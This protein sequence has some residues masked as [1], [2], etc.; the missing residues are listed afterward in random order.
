[1]AS[2]TDDDD[3][4]EDNKVETFE[5]KWGIL[6]KGSKGTYFKSGPLVAWKDYKALQD[7]VKRLEQ[8]LEECEMEHLVRSE[9]M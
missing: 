8:E 6:C 4:D 9:F 1:M 2:N 3:S 5:Y 7:E